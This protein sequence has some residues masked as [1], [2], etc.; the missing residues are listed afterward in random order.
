[1]K[2]PRFK[3]GAF[4]RRAPKNGLFFVPGKDPL[5]VGIEQCIGLK[6]RPGAEVHLLSQNLG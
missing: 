5:A 3:D 6:I 1:M 2:L 4:R